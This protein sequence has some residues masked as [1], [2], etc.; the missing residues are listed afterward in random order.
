VLDDFQDWKEFLHNRVEQ[1]EALGFSRDTIN[2]WAYRI[3]DYLAKNVQPKNTQEKVLRDL[4]G[5]AT[6]EEQR[7]LAG[8][9][10]KLVEKSS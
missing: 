7:M 8:L 2:T 6:E 10:V 3:G 4:W 5:V 1:A 9:M